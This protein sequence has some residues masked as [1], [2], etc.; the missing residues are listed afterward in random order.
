MFGSVIG[1]MHCDASW[2]GD[3]DEIGLV[4]VSGT[5]NAISNGQKGVEPLDEGR[6]TIK[7]V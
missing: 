2:G 7:K 4:R 6:V 5:F 1:R 3:G